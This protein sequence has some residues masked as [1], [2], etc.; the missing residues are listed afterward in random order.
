MTTTLG[1][2]S[3]RIDERIPEYISETY[4]LFAKFLKNYYESLESKYSSLDLVD[5]LLEYYNIQNYTPKDL[6]KST[7]ITTK[8]DVSLD[9]INVISTV[10]FPHTNGYIKIDNEIIFYKEKT[11]TSFTGCVRG[12]SAITDYNRTTGD[13][14]FSDSVPAIHAKNAQVINLAY[15]FTTEFITRFKNEVLPGFPQDLPSDLN[16]RVLFKNIKEFYL[17]KGTPRS[18]KFLFRILFNQKYVKLKVENA[19]VGPKIRVNVFSGKIGSSD[20]NTLGYEIINNDIPGQAPTTNYGFN[21]EPSSYP[22]V[23]VVGNGENASVIVNNIVDS[24]YGGRIPPDGLTIVNRGKN[25]K[26]QVILEVYEKEF[27]QEQKVIGQ[28]SGAFGFVKYWN[29]GTGELTLYN[30]VGVFSPGEVLEG[31]RKLK[32]DQIPRRKVKSLIRKVLSNDI[33]GNPNEYIDLEPIEITTVDP[34]IEYPF[35]NVLRPSASKYETREILKCEYVTSTNGETDLALL[36][37]SE[38]LFLIQELD[39]E[40]DAGVCIPFTQL[41]II[42]IDKVYDDKLGKIIFDINTTERSITENIFLPPQTRLTQSLSSSSTTVSVDSTVGFPARNGIIRIGAETIRYKNKSINQ[43]LECERQYVDYFGD[44]TYI[45]VTPQSEGTE[46]SLIGRY[47]S[48]LLKNHWYLLKINLDNTGENFALLRVISVPGKIIIDDGGSLF[49]ETTFEEKEDYSEFSEPIHTSW[50][51]SFGSSANNGLASLYEDEAKKYVYIASSGTPPYTTSQTR[52]YANQKHIKRI[53]KAKLSYDA[54]KNPSVNQRGIGLTNDG[55]EINSYTGN[56]ITYGRIESVTISNNGSGYIL[57][58]RLHERLPYVKITGAGESTQVLTTRTSKI[59]SIYSSFVSVSLDGIDESLLT[60]SGTVGINDQKA[61]VT[62]SRSSGDITGKGAELRTEVVGGK[63]VKILISSAGEY[64]TKT[65]IVKVTGPGIDFTVPQNNIVM[66]GS[67]GVAID[68]ITFRPFTRSQVNSLD[69]N[70]LAYKTITLTDSERKNSYTENPKLIVDTGSGATG[71]AEIFNNQVRSVIIDKEGENYYVPPIVKFI[72]DGKNA[73]GIA[74]IDSNGKVI[75]VDIINGGEN[76]TIPPVVKFISRGSLFA[77]KTT[78]TQWT[79]V[80][81]EVLSSKIDNYGGYVFNYSDSPLVTTDQVPDTKNYPEYLQIK[82]TAPILN[83]LDK[84]TVIPY[85]P[86]FTSFDSSFTNVTYQFTRETAGFFEIGDEVIIDT[87]YSSRFGTFV[88][89]E[90]PSYLPTGNAFIWTINA[91]N[92]GLQTGDRIIINFPSAVNANG[93]PDLTNLIIF[94][95]NND[96]FR[97]HLG[98]FI[99]Q[100]ASNRTRINNC[101]VTGSVS[102]TLMNTKIAATV[103]AFTSVPNIPNSNVINASSVTLRLPRPYDPNVFYTTN[104]IIIPRNKHSSIIGW[105]YDGNPIYGRL[106]FSDPITSDLKSRVTLQ[107]SSYKI[108]YGTFTDERTGAQ[109]VIPIPAYRPSVDTYPIGS[110]V[111]DYVFDPKFGT[112]D[113]YNGKFCVTPDFPT[114]TYAYFATEFYPYFIGPLFRNKIDSYNT[115]QKYLNSSLPPGLKRIKSDD[116]DFP[117]F[118]KSSNLSSKTRSE[119]T[120]FYTGGVENV[121]IDYAGNNYKT[122]DTLVINNNETGGSGFNAVIDEVSGQ[123]TRNYTTSLNTVQTS[124]DRLYIYGELAEIQIHQ[125]KPHMLESGDKITVERIKPSVDFVDTIYSGT[126]KTYTGTLYNNGTITGLSSIS[127]IEV[128]STITN[129]GVLS[130]DGATVTSIDSASSITITPSEFY[131]TQF[132]PITFTTDK[133]YSFEDQ[134]FGLEKTSNITVYENSKYTFSLK[135]IKV[136]VYWSY[137]L[138][139]GQYF[140]RYTK[141]SNTPFNWSTIKAR[142]FAPDGSVIDYG[143]MIFSSGRIGDPTNPTNIITPYDATNITTGQN[144]YVQFVRDSGSYID[145]YVGNSDSRPVLDSNGNP[146]F[147]SNGNPI[148]NAYDPLNLN[149]NGLSTIEYPEYFAEN[150]SVVGPYSGRSITPPVNYI[151]SFDLASKSLYFSEDNIGQFLFLNKNAYLIDNHE[152]FIKPTT[153][154]SDL[155]NVYLQ[156]RD[157][158]L[159]KTVK[160]FTLDFENEIFEGTYPIEKIDDYKFKFSKTIPEEYKVYNYGNLELTNLTIDSVGNLTGISQSNIANLKVGMV[161]THSDLVLVSCAT[162]AN[163]PV[164]QET[165]TTLTGPTGNDA[166]RFPAVDTVIQ[167]VGSTIAGS[168]VITLSQ[169]ERNK[170]NQIRYLEYNISGNGIPP[171]AFMVPNFTNNSFELFSFDGSTIIPAFATQTAQNVTLQISI[172]TIKVGNT[173]QCVLVKNQTIPSQNGV[174]VLTRQGVQGTTAWQLTRLLGWSPIDKTKIGNYYVGVRDGSQRGVYDNDF[175]TTTGIFGTTPITFTLDP[176]RGMMYAWWTNNINLIKTIGSSVVGLNWQYFSLPGIV[177]INVGNVRIH[178]TSPRSYNMNSIDWYTRSSTVSGPIRSVKIIDGGKGYKKLPEITGVSS[179]Y[180]YGAKLQADSNTIGKIKK[181]DYITVGDFYGN[182][183]TIDF[184][185]QSDVVLKLKQNYEISSVTILDRGENYYVEPT[186][187]V[188]E[189]IPLTELAGIYDPPIQFKTTIQS[190]KLQTVEVV[191]GGNFLLDT[192]ELIVDASGTGGSGALVRANLSRSVLN[193]D[194]IISI[195][196]VT[197]AVSYIQSVNTNQSNI[198]FE[199]NHN[200]KSND[201]VLYECTGLPLVTNPPDIFANQ[202][203]LYV[204][205]VDATTIQLSTIPAGPAI[206]LLPGSFINEKNLHKISKLPVFETIATAKVVSYDKNNSTVQLKEISGN[207]ISKDFFGNY[208]WESA[209]LFDERQVPFSTILKATKSKTRFKSSFTSVLKPRFTNNIGFIS[210]A[211]QKITDSNYY[212]IYSYLIGYN[213]NVKDWYNLIYKN[214]HAIGNKLFGKHII[215]SNQ[216]V[217]Q[218]TQGII[219]NIIGFNLTL[220]NIL[221]LKLNYSVINQQILYLNDVAPQALSA[222]GVIVGGTSQAIA[223]VDNISNTILFITSKNGLQFTNGEN[224]YYYKPQYLFSPRIKTD[225][226][227]SLVVYNGVLQ[228]PNDSYT[229]DENKL[230]LAFPVNDKD[231]IFI[232]Q[233]SSLVSD[234]FEN[235][236]PVISDSWDFG[237]DM[238]QYTKLFTA[239]IPPKDAKDI[240]TFRSIIGDGTDRIVLQRSGETVNISNSLKNKLIVSVNGVVLDST[241]YSILNGNVVVLTTGN[242][243]PEGSKVFALYFDALQKLFFTKINDYTYKINNLSTLTVKRSSLLLS[244]NGAIQ[245]STDSV[246]EQSRFTIAGTFLTFDEPIASTAF[247]HGWLIN[248]KC[249]TENLDTSVFEERFV[250][251]SLNITRDKLITRTFESNKK[252]NFNNKYQQVKRK[253]LSGTAYSGTS[254]GNP[255][256]DGTY[257]YGNDTKFVTTFPEQSSSFVELVENISSQFNGIKKEFILKSPN[258]ELTFLNEFDFRDSQ[259]NLT[260]PPPSP[261]ANLIHTNFILNDSEKLL[262]T[263]NNLPLVLGEDYTLNYDEDGQKIIFVNAPSVGSNCCIFYFQSTYDSKDIVVGQDYFDGSRKTFFLNEDGIPLYVRNSGD[264]LAIRNGV[265]QPFGSGF[266][267]SIL[268]TV[269]FDEPPLPSDDIKLLYF[270]K[271]LLS[272]NSVKDPNNY[273]LDIPGYID[274]IRNT[275]TLTKDGYPLLVN[276]VNKIFPFR[277]EGIYQYYLNSYS[278][279]NNALTFVDS[280]QINE[281]LFIMAFNTTT[282]IT[283]LQFEQFSSNSLKLRNTVNLD[284]ATQTMIIFVNG[285]MQQYNPQIGSWTWTTDVPDNIPDNRFFT[286]LNYITDD[287]DFIDYSNYELYQSPNILPDGEFVILFDGTINVLIDDIKIY[288]V[289]FA[290]TLDYI[291]T[292]GGGLNIEERTTNTAFDITYSTLP[293]AVEKEDSILVNV[294]GITQNPGVAYKIQKT[295]LSQVLEFDYLEDSPGGLFG[296]SNKISDSGNFLV[297]SAPL[298]E[299]TIIGS[300]GVVRLY[301][302]TQNNWTLITSLSISRTDRGYPGSSL[303][304]GYSVD[305]TKDCEKIVVGC[306]LWATATNEEVGAVSFYNTVISTSGAVT[307]SRNTF[308]KAPTGINSGARFGHQV[309]IDKF[310]KIAAV[311]APFENVNGVIASGAVYIYRFD[312]ELG[313]WFFDKKITPKYPQTNEN[314][315]ISLDISA[316]SSILSVG[317][318]QQ[319]YIFNYFENLWYEEDQ[320]TPDDVQPFDSFGNSISITEDGN[321]LI[322]GSPRDTSNTLIQTRAFEYLQYISDD[323]EIF[324]RENMISQKLNSSINLICGTAYIFVRSGTNL[325]GFKWVLEQKITPQNPDYD[326]EFGFAVSISS[327]GTRVVI[328]SPNRANEITNQP[329]GKVYVYDFSNQQLGN[330]YGPWQLTQ[331]ISNQNALIYDRF[332][333]S[334]SMSSSGNSLIIGAPYDDNSWGVNS[335]TI[336]YYAGSRIN[337]IDGVTNLSNVMITDF[338]RMNLCK[339]DSFDERMNGTNTRFR[340]IRNKIPFTRWRNT[341]DILISVNGVLR[342]P[343]IDYFVENGY[344]NFRQNPPNDSTDEIYIIAMFNNQLLRLENLADGKTKVDKIINS[345]TI[346]LLPSSGHTPGNIAFK[347]LDSSIVDQTTYIGTLSED[348]YVTNIQDTSSITVGV[349]VQKSYGTGVF[350]SGPLNTFS[351]SDDALGQ[352]GSENRNIIDDSLIVQVNGV[353]QTYNSGFTYLNNNKFKLDS[354]LDTDPDG[355]AAN[356]FAIRLDSL[357]IL[358]NINNGFNGSNKTFPLFYNSKNFVPTGTVE[359]DSVPSPRNLLVFKNDKILEPFEEYNLTGPIKSKINFTVAPTSTDKFII[360]NLGLFKQLDKITTGFN[361]STKIFYMKYQ[362]LDYYPNAEIERPRDYE[363]QIL[364]I[365]DGY[366][367]NSLVDYYIDHN[368]IVFTNAPASNTVEIMLYDFMGRKEDVSVIDRVENIQV[369]DTIKLSGDTDVRKVTQVISPSLLRTSTYNGITKGIGLSVSPV[370]SNGKITNATVTSTGF[371]YPENLVISAVGTGSGGE[372]IV[373]DVSYTNGGR[374]STSNLEIID[375]GFN[376]FNA[377]TLRINRPIEIVRK[378]MFSSSFTRKLY[379]LTS[380]VTTSSVDIDMQ[381]VSGLPTSNINIKIISTTGSVSS[382]SGAVLKPYVYGGEIVKVDIIN[383]GSGYDLANTILIVEGGGGSGAELKPVLNS[384]GKFVQVTIINAGIGYDYHSVIIGKETVYYTI[385]NPT[386][387]KL[388]SCTR[389]NPQNWSSSTYVIYDKEL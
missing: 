41:N 382:G 380:N 107:T 294:N 360:R 378:D 114:G 353:V 365:K 31:V 235:F 134:A 179:S 276:N 309:S 328:G 91:T 49:T 385:A 303:Q 55:I 165:E 383:A 155:P 209:Y 98:Q 237:G 204:K 316:D 271:L 187:K 45:P 137:D 94:K 167:I 159:E 372:I 133:S 36:E 48:K 135:K 22:L 327:D 125:E 27:V 298:K 347:L 50:I 338:S 84:S 273:L 387:L 199:T 389:P 119:V 239:Q 68:P 166:G 6:V 23:N 261:S 280:P 128:G 250:S 296:F 40:H 105:A 285:V 67:V 263:I 300:T 183:R 120:Q 138:G 275:F 109:I 356:I 81:P 201:L 95:Q 279:S 315:G 39:D 240:V 253:L 361:N 226:L 143:D 184:D 213:T 265:L 223:K 310:G 258:S 329:E 324:D 150:G 272:P 83:R 307:V 268:N 64:Y 374:V 260:S 312:V 238:S 57:P 7:S 319:V 305:I 282:Q 60:F 93:I 161:V 175:N 162:I 140:I 8:L 295:N 254:S 141:D 208:I 346:K 284:V 51:S 182:D 121:Y 73:A 63:I 193:K 335:G 371:D 52:T 180:G 82:P 87:Q 156:V 220:K 214:S 234:F 264:V 118:P 16:L 80:I 197:D 267:T 153:K 322:V 211:T 274:G 178:S 100:T 71:F 367:Q 342:T 24:P 54:V 341:S 225:T 18:H 4:P 289:P 388:E 127:G 233:T 354:P 130:W 152:V 75:D 72:G 168:R 189:D 232:I 215:E 158:I 123:I 348:G 321:K 17:S 46:V 349:V 286:I 59:I 102:F 115:T 21:L 207:I 376:Y 101:P 318:R 44:K 368:R 370:I 14:T 131:P 359:D 314:F 244:V 344:I 358:D 386:T 85:I 148:L 116:S 229:V 196:K 1:K 53:P 111:D 355:P 333:D 76:Y 77:T 144:F 47:N 62:V 79:P 301:R 248:N 113:Q 30:T 195:K 78:I 11:R 129:T 151:I 20:Q 157:E 252:V 92:H 186:I 259:G 37:N 291:A 331:T 306:P 160:N 217:Y 332:G 74:V 292:G 343:Y 174:Y 108:R 154:E 351:F 317:T 337:F 231:K 147:D 146:T 142:K 2:V 364:V 205:I 308:V 66:S 218:N 15:I 96:Q 110:L 228:E 194:S 293:Y 304:F 330:N 34:S 181:I 89:P 70:P 210:E 270:R 245:N 219:K 362:G 164:S 246:I 230:S 206:T 28:T 243:F 288:F 136:S 163:L 13:V 283:E 12:S 326:Q 173:N 369:G 188:K 222:G 221:N 212:Q 381:T 297:V 104:E 336:Y 366:I 287:N 33:Y 299:T 262:V 266:V 126:R 363:N 190:G 69:F 242:I 352:L 320:I 103:I 323:S 122:G 56:K 132:A 42:N 247:I 302:K 350:Y 88:R 192:P 257:I 311:S 29:A 249:Y 145:I 379:R 251:T 3:S 384:T 99:S 325:T 290:T 38:G 236:L 200:F 106:A 241:L 373:K 25:Y 19:G 35:E 203:Q 345:S 278:Y 169:S 269:S 65:P 256:V 313:K 90:Q 58:Q 86:V 191:S 43:F 139:R 26:G 9:T 172:T 149:P 377:P 202:V 117:Y 176:S 224:V 177:N 10:G 170:F 198:I 334:L 340:L 32:S 5:N 255:S 277:F 281:P 61:T 124:N 375:S 185:L 97:I 227:N 357:V 216:S 171:N 339:V 112:L